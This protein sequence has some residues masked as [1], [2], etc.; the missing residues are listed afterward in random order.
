MTMQGIAWRRCLSPLTVVTSAVWLAATCAVVYAMHYHRGDEVKRARLDMTLCL[1]AG[2]LFG[3]IGGAVAGRM[4]R[5]VG[6]MSQRGAFA[7]FALL[8]VAL[9]LLGAWVAN[10]G[11]MGPTAW[12]WRGAIAFGVITG[13]A[14]MVSFLVLLWGRIAPVA[15]LF[16]W[17]VVEGS[18]R[19]ANSSVG[20]LLDRV[21]DGGVASQAGFS[22][23]LGICGLMCL[24]CVAGLVSNRLRISW[25][26]R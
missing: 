17:S 25:A 8:M 24:L 11:R 2:L 22:V 13:S 14:S 4:R 1:L 19:M 10:V 16:A 12:W 6:L 23:F 15:M 7:R 5:A 18:L 9:G 20:Q 3:A 26:Q 21:A